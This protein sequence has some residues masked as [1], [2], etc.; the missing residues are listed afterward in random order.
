LNPILDFGL[1]ARE[2]SDERIF[3]EVSFQQSKI[4]NPKSK[5]GGGLLLSLSLSHFAV[6]WRWRSRRRK[7]P[8]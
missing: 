7:S 3:F 1:K 5:M 4:G 2:Q 8:G 6:R